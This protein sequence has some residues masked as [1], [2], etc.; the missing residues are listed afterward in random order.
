MTIRKLVDGTF[1]AITAFLIVGM[2]VLTLLQVITRYGLNA[3]FEWTEELARL[4]LIYLTF[5]GSVVA[6]RR[7][8]HL[9]IETLVNALPARS[10]QIILVMVDVAS[11][12]VLAFVVWQG[13]PLLF[14]F[15]GL[16]SAALGWPTTFFYLPVVFGCLVMMIY[17][18]FDAVARMSGDGK[19]QVHCDGEPQ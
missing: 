6:L 10:R 5:L 16:Q 4:D 9:R 13:V 1:E 15:W 3:G 17:F 12:A 11:V 8:E 2:V 18:C 14:R 7:Q 19:E